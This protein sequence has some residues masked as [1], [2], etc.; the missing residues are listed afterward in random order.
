[1]PNISP[2]N[3]ILGFVSAEGA[4]RERAFTVV[5]D[6]NNKSLPLLRDNLS[7]IFVL[8]QIDSITGPYRVNNSPYN[9]HGCP[10]SDNCSFD[11]FITE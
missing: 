11:R 5:D 8:L 9:M 3:I 4:I 6:G 2:P 1:M 10:L 7:S